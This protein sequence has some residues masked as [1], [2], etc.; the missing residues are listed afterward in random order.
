MGRQAEITTDIL[1]N[2][3][4]RL[5][6]E[7]LRIFEVIPISSPADRRLYCIVFCATL[8]PPFHN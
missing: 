7:L 4:A 2:H 1:T 8:S 5:L 3:V 6:I